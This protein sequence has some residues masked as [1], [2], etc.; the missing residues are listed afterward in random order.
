[1]NGKVNIG[2]YDATGLIFNVEQFSKWSAGTSTEAS[3]QHNFLSSEAD[4]YINIK[5]L[6][7]KT[8]KETNPS[9]PTTAFANINKENDLTIA[10]N[11]GT[12]TGLVKLRFTNTDSAG[13][14]RT[15]YSEDIFNIKNEYSTIYCQIPND[16]SCWY[17]QDWKVE[18]LDIAGNPIKSTDKMEYYTI[19]DANGLKGFANATNVGAKTESRIFYLINDINLNNIAIN[20]ICQSTSNWFDG[21]FGSGIYNEEEYVEKGGQH[22]ISNLKVNV[23]FN[24]SNQDYAFGLFGWA[25]AKA[26]I[27]NLKIDSI[28]INNNGVT[29]K[30]KVGG[31]AGFADAGNYISNIIVSNSNITGSA[32]VGGLVGYSKKAIG[33]S[34]INNTSV[35]SIGTQNVIEISGKKYNT[36][37]VGGIAGL[38][39]GSATI[40]T[41]KIY[42]S[43]KIG[44][45]SIKIND[46]ISYNKDRYYVGGI[47]GCAKT[48]VNTPKVES[49]VTVK[50]GEIK[51]TVWDN[52]KE[53]YT[54]GVIGYKETNQKID[55]TFD[56]ACSVSGYDN[57]GGIIGFNASGDI[58]SVSFKGT[59]TG[60][61]ENIG[62]IV[63]SNTG[64]NISNCTNSITIN[65]QGKNV[66]GIVGLNSGKNISNCT[67]HGSVTGKKNVGGITGITYGSTV[68]S[69]SNFGTIKSAEGFGPDYWIMWDEYTGTGGIAGKLYGSK[70]EQCSNLGN[71][72]S[73]VNV[74]GIA[75]LNWCSKVYYSYNK[76]NINATSIS[77]QVGGICGHGSGVDIKGSY[78]IGTIAGQKDVAGIMGSCV[79]DTKY[80]DINLGYYEGHLLNKYIYLDF[81]PGEIHNYFSYCYNSGTV[82]DTSGLI[83]DTGGIL[84][85]RM[86]G[87]NEISMDIT[88]VECYYL[89]NVVHTDYKT[90]E[91]DYD[92]P[93]VHKMSAQELKKQLY[94]WTND[95]GV[96]VG[97]NTYVYN[98]IT[99][100]ATD[101]GYGGFGVL[102]WEIPD[103]Q[104]LETN[105]FL[106]MRSKNNGSETYRNFRNT[107]F[108]Q[109]IFLTDSISINYKDLEFLGCRISK[110]KVGTSPVGQISDGCYRYIMMVPKAE[111]TIKPRTNADETGTEIKSKLYNG[112]NYIKEDTTFS[113]NVTSNTT[114]WIAYVLTTETKTIT[115]NRWS[116]EFRKDTGLTA[117]NWYTTK[118]KSDKYKYKDAFIRYDPGDSM[119]RIAK[120]FDG[121]YV[122][123]DKPA[124]VQY[125][126]AKD[127]TSL[128]FRYGIWYGPYKFNYD[129]KIKG[130]TEVSKIQSNEVT[131][132]GSAYVEFGSLAD[133]GASTS[134]AI[135][136]AELELTFDVDMKWDG[137]GKLVGFF[138]KIFGDSGKVKFNCTL[139]KFNGKNWTTIHEFK[140][141]DFALPTNYSASDTNSRLDS[142]DKFD[143]T[144]NKR[145]TASFRVPSTYLNDSIRGTKAN[146][147]LRLKMNIENQD[148][149][150]VIFYFTSAKLTVEYGMD[151][152]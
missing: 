52:N 78:N 135:Y 46:N 21:Y 29:G 65:A 95:E 90:P 84:G 128:Y 106:C 75:G 127:N 5:V 83:D 124:K 68:K 120:G 122:L 35:S 11:T 85:K 101:K 149:E 148:D 49:T 1:M 73:T 150:K 66:G 38:T 87:F 8:Y 107:A 111:Y 82:N 53:T 125:R 81:T 15:Y 93:N 131:A 136:N 56:V 10:T 45:G 9:A 27:E 25:G 39:E 133:L 116:F 40:N 41:C 47:V 121:G 96:F 32:Y 33:N 113:V 117:K 109:K 141:K 61:G 151:G 100:L 36:I 51:G 64:G 126:V 132:Q 3:G 54:G 91:L 19:K 24:G 28:T 139:E 152:M 115:P 31:L 130:N 74:G 137:S 2:N 71:I 97:N 67:N 69:C 63:G 37:Y 123:L 104:R 62:G 118:N 17:N 102:W 146:E 140:N 92:D 144:F 7:E 48:Y 86:I 18:V 147:K 58:D 70:V 22:S 103:Y 30:H 94:K 59:I 138:N 77:G 145:Y 34:E 129:D 80:P 20:P 6:Y 89:N 42:N 57:V 134:T 98:T 142:E 143:Y 119:A 88:F 55:S 60:N 43:S 99:P 76:G 4:G 108:E 44:E 13:N 110:E 14:K 72:E 26:T 50:G 105:M 23:K 114:L 12:I 16:S 79:N 112:N